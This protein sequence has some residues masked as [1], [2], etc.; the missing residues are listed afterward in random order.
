MSVRRRRLDGKS[1]SIRPPHRPSGT[2]VRSHGGSSREHVRVDV[3][4]LGHAGL[5]VETRHGSVLCD[6]W[7]TPAYFGSWFPF[8]RNDGLDPERFRRPDYLYVSHLH[9]DHF[10]PEWLAAPRGQGRPGAA[11]RSSASPPRA[12]S[13][14]RS[15]FRDFVQT[16]ARR[17][18]RPRRPRRDDPR[19]DVARRRSARRLRDRARRRLGAAAQPERRPPRRPRRAAGARPV[20]RA[21][22]AVLGRDLV[23]DRLRLPRRGEGP[24]GARQARRRDG[25]RRGS[26]SRRSTPRTSSRARGRRASS[27]TSCSRST[28]ST[29]DPPNIFP[30]Q[31]VFLDRAR[32]RGDRH[33]APDRARLGRRARRRRRARCRAP[34]RRPTPREPFADKAA[35]LDEYRARL[36]R[37]ARGRTGESWTRPGRDLVAELARVVRTAARAGADHVGRHRRQRRA[38]TSAPTTP[39]SA[40]TSSSR[41]CGVGAASRTSTRS[42]STAR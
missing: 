7:F 4:F 30:D 15:G 23:P 18:A 9:R 6:P 21:A 39:T 8:P 32:G 22:A 25:A 24:A 11:A 42:T 20:R 2:C 19:D 3:T 28:T 26:T 40:S 29:D 35:Y 13:S 41:R 34:G 5:F 38:S 17:A 1:R 12:V 36:G 10:D 27:T 31:P 33:A 16:R 14:R 37:L